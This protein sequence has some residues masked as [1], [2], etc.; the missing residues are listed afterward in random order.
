MLGVSFTFSSTVNKLKICFVSDLFGHGCLFN[1]F[2][3]FD[4]DIVFLLCLLWL[5][6]RVLNLL[7]CIKDLYI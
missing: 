6:I 7:N 1:G 3:I 5:L 4:L 2:M